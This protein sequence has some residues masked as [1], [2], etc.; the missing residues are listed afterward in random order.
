[1]QQALQLPVATLSVHY[2]KDRRRPDP[3]HPRSW[4]FKIVNRSQNKEFDHDCVNI[5]VSP[6]RPGY[7]LRSWIRVENVLAYRRMDILLRLPL[8]CSMCCRNLV[9]MGVSRCPG[10]SLPHA[11]WVR[12]A[13]MANP[14]AISDQVEIVQSD[15]HSFVTYVDTLKTTY[16]HRMHDD[17]R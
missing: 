7:R 6:I 2:P 11:V 15:T 12:S 10:T 14:T 3:H 1:M 9:D 13:S 5:P 16:I 8:S 4:S 17:H